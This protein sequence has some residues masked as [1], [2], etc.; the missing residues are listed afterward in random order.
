MIKAIIT[1]FDGTLVDTFEANYQAYTKAFQRYADEIGKDLSREQ[2]HS[3][4]GM[5]FDSFMSTMGINDLTLRYKI[6]EEKT[7]VYPSCFS[8]FVPNTSLIAFIRCMKASGVKTA[9]ASTARRENLMNALTYLELED[10]FDLIL[11]GEQ[12]TEGKPNPEI[13]L[14]TMRKLDVMPQETLVFEDSEVG[15]QAAEASGANYFKI[16]THSFHP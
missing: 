5:R 2:Y 8:H 9:I 12:V 14:T 13:Y 15:L 10:V 6:R 7:K 4:F 16:T 3:C 11:A 1:D